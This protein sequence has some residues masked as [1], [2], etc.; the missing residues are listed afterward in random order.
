MVQA[1]LKLFKRGHRP[2]FQVRLP[3]QTAVAAFSAM[4][5]ALVALLT[6]QPWDGSLLSPEVALAH[7]YEDLSAVRSVH[8]VE[9]VVT[10]VTGGTTMYLP[11]GYKL[12]GYDPQDRGASVSVFK[13]YE[14]RAER[15]DC[16]TTPPA[17]ESCRLVDKVTGEWVGVARR[18]REVQIIEGAYVFPGK[19]YKKTTKVTVDPRDM[20]RFSLPRELRNGTSPQPAFNL[21]PTGAVKKREQVTEQLYVHGEFYYRSGGQPW[22][23]SGVSTTRGVRRS[24]LFREV[25]QGVKSLDRAA[26]VVARLQAGGADGGQLERHSPWDSAHQLSDYELDGAPTSHYLLQRRD[27]GGYTRSLE[28]WVDKKTGLPVKVVRTMTKGTEPHSTTAYRFSKFNELLDL[29][30]PTEVAEN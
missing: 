4:V 1:T 30:S 10:R 6:L 25:F 3:R 27:A 5:L 22:L 24:V 11:L 2:L 14:D 18:S 20:G 8:V 9:E 26:N 7:A 21:E 19:Y 17:I 12:A 28:V 13:M 29:P 16:V 15:A 23:K